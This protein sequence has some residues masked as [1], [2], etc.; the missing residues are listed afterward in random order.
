MTASSSPAP[1]STANSPRQ[2]TAWMTNAP[3][4]GAT[5]GARLSTATMKDWIVARCCGWGKTSR[6][7]AMPATDAA[8]APKPWTARQP[9]S[10]APSAASV[11]AMAAATYTARP[12]RM[13]RRR[14]WR[15]D[16][17]PQ[18]SW[19]NPKVSMNAPS[20]AC[21]CESVAPSS[22]PMAGSP[23][24]LMSMD[25]GG[26]PASMPSTTMKPTGN[27]I[28]VGGECL[29]CTKRSPG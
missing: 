14:P 4:S 16:K 18:A 6:T 19:P 7:S 20:V 11:Q 27:A 8:D 22:A 13:T 5:M 10:A 26:R 9:I 24:R 15:S 12:S 1:A 29:A 3:I 17:G 21:I 25:R 28:R 2:P 23:G